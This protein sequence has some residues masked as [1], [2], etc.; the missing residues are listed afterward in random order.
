[1]TLIGRRASVEGFKENQG[2]LRGRIDYMVVQ[3][4]HRDLIMMERKPAGW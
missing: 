2:L 4:D 3:S 1:M